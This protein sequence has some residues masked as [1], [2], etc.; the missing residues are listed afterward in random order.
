MNNLIDRM[1]M[2]VQRPTSPVEPL[3][4][5][6]YASRPNT[7]VESVVNSTQ[8]IESLRETDPT[9]II[10]RSS[11]SRLQV[12]HVLAQTPLGESTEPVRTNALR[13]EHF[14]DPAIPEA[15]APPLHL[16]KLEPLPAAIPQL[17]ESESPSPQP[18]RPTQ[19][20]TKHVQGV[21]EKESPKLVST[22]LATPPSQ[23]IRAE[24][25]DQRN[26]RNQ[27]QPA[28]TTEVNISI[29]H[30]EVRAIQRSEPVRRS[31]PPPSHVT[32]EDYL[33]RR[34]GASR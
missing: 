19:G 13:G 16:P 9:F 26:I 15:S 21:H 29:G 33:R 11:E 22:R 32:L 12:Q 3:L 30:I 14:S 4:P 34:P 7:L 23:K 8:A 6:L 25:V 31:V 28:S 17:Y 20:T 10:K 18:H 2:R 1:I 27:L 5:Q 24:K